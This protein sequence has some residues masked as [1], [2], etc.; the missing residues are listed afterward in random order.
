MDQRRP[1]RHPFFLQ[2]IPGKCTC[3]KYPENEPRK[4]G[5]HTFVQKDGDIKREKIYFVF[6]ANIHTYFF[7]HI[8]K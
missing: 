8:G 6:M 5:G 2:E 7:W 3:Q 4:P 1:G